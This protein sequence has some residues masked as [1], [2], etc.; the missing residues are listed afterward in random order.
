MHL[1]E[2]RRTS[3]ELLSCLEKEREELRTKLK[4]ATNEVSQTYIFMSVFCL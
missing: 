4:D 1:E 2:K 3:E